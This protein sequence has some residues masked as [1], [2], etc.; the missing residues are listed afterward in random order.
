[1]RQSRVLTRNHDHQ[2]RDGVKTI[3]GGLVFL[4]LSANGVTQVPRYSQVALHH[5]KPYR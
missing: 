4:R 1:M 5:A 2:Q 3:Q